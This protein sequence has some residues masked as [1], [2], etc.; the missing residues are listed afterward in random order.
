MTSNEFYWRF[1]EIAVTC[2][3][4][5]TDIL[6]EAGIANTTLHRWRTGEAQPTT[7]TWQRVIAAAERLKAK[8]RA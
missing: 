6:R 4:K 3:V 1:Q 2:R 8:A 5:P 7:R